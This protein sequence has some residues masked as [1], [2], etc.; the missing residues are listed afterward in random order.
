MAHQLELKASIELHNI[1]AKLMIHKQFDA[2]VPSIKTKNLLKVRT[3]I[4][5]D[6]LAEQLNVRTR[7]QLKQ[8]VLENVHRPENEK[9]LR[10]FTYHEMHQRSLIHEIYTGQKQRKMKVP[11]YLQV[12]LSNEAI[13]EE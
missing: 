9:Y 10:N 3:N 8:R 4:P 2:F 13:S 6:V 7:E 5:E 11:A 1:Y 12:T